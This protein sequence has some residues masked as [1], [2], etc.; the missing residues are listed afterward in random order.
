[1]YLFRVLFVSLPSGLRLYVIYER[2]NTRYVIYERKI[3]VFGLAKGSRGHA[4][5]AVH[6]A[7]DW[8]ICA[9]TIRLSSK[10]S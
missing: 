1:V 9:K 4:D 5:S 6:V 7:N 8:N 3:F 2:K 10:D